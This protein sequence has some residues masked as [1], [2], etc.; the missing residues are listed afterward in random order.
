MT[1]G[2]RSSFCTDG[3]NKFSKYWPSQGTLRHVHVYD[4]KNPFRPENAGYFVPP[5][6]ARM[7]DLR[8]NRP[9]I[10]QS[11]DCFVD[12]NGVMYVTDNNAGLY[13]LQFEGK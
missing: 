1:P 6:P 11:A 2:K 13:I 3:S 8:P 12:K 9:Q 4:I 10:I 7:F 5:N